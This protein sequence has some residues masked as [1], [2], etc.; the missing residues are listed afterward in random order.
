LQID[1]DVL[2]KSYPPPSTSPRPSSC[3]SIFLTTSESLDIKLF[4]KLT[5][6]KILKNKFISKFNC[7]ARALV[8]EISARSKSVVCI[9][10][11]YVLINFLF[12]IF[13]NGCK[14]IIIAILQVIHNIATIICCTFLK[15]RTS[16]YPTVFSCLPHEHVTRPNANGIA[17]PTKKIERKPVVTKHKNGGGIVARASP[18]VGKHV[19]FR[20]SRLLMASSSL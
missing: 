12:Y 10:M 9:Q 15:N 7:L 1:L 11:S 8:I 3:S 4:C 14:I 5:Y 18:V 17:Q 19:Q 2:V 16:N 13:I 20:V 6:D